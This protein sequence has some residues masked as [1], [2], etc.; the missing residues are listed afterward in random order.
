[1]AMKVRLELISP[2]D[3]DIHAQRRDDAE[4]GEI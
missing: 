4:Y 2:L 1:M 3:E